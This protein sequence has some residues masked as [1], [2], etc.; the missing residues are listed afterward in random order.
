MSIRGGSVSI[1][2]LTPSERA[3]FTAEQMSSKQDV[4][5][6]MTVAQVRPVAFFTRVASKVFMM[7]SMRNRGKKRAVVRRDGR[8]VAVEPETRQG[9]YCST[10]S[11]SSS[12]VNTLRSRCCGRRASEDRTRGT[13]QHHSHWHR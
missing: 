4:Q 5:R 12:S 10:M 13:S 2:V 8:T 11:L 1:L 9:T 3:C 7:L 6:Y